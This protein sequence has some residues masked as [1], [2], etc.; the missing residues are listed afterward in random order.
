M[1]DYILNVNKVV[2]EL[3]NIFN[4]D[5]SKKYI[6]LISLYR[7]LCMVDVLNDKLNKKYHIEA[8]NDICCY[9]SRII[10]YKESLIN[11]IKEKKLKYFIEYQ[12]IYVYEKISFKEYVNQYMDE[13]GLSYE[14][15]GIP[16]LLVGC[17]I[18]NICPVSD[19]DDELIFL[20]L[21]EIKQ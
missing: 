3:N 15:F 5:N 12:S 2:I 8:I 21:K 1:T 11:H 13:I 17:E 10:K 19:D 6:L 4:T 9:T 7:A 16:H 14:R 18:K 20:N